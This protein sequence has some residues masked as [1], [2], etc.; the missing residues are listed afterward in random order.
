ML[1]KLLKQ[2]LRKKLLAGMSLVLIATGVYFGYQELNKDD[3]A[4]RYIT[5]AVKKGTLI[6][7]LS[8]S[9]QVSA[10]NQADI[11]PKVSGDVVYVGVKNG[12][13]VKAGTLIAQL[14]AQ[15]AQKAVRDAEINLESAQLSLDKLKLQ[16]QQELRGDTLNKTYED[17][18]KVLADFYEELGTILRDVDNILFGNDLSNNKDNI[19]YYANYFLP[20]NQ[21]SSIPQSAERLFSDIEKVYREALTDF[22]NAQRGSGDEREQAI[23]SGYKLTVKT[24]Q[25]IKFGRDAIRPLYDAF[26]PSVSSSIHAKWDVIENHNNDLSTYAST[27][28]AS[29]QSLL[30]VQN[31]INSQQDLIENQP[32]DLRSQEI[33][34]KQRENALLDAQ[35]KLANYYIRAPFNGVIAQ[36]NAKKGDSV[37]SAS[38]LATLITRQKLA[39]ISLNEVDVAQI[40]IG[41]KATLTFDAVP[42]LTISGQVVEVDAVGTVSQGVVTYTVK[43]G[44]DTQDDRVKTGMSVS[45]AIVT[46]VKPDILLVPNSA[47]KS[48]GDMSYVEILEEGDR[49]AALTAN[50]NGAIL[51]NPPRRQAVKTGL[52]ND[53][54]TEI[55]SG[56]NE[57]D[58]VVTRTIQPNSTQT[59]TQSSQGR[60]KI[61]V[62]MR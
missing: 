43:I 20:Y 54:F 57:G 21:K 8:G 52:S 29:L 42:D 55:I 14:D 17:G 1:T 25:L 11:K 49:D 16:Q 18:M 33:T 45:A 2:I 41:Q 5:A 26:N 51:K 10:S 35:E 40:K 53:E 12:Q 31:S 23:A 37:S 48:E 22:Q 38:I 3:N 58:V 4:T 13:E 46:K 7:S 27:V 44:F 24:A 9:G 36:V 50:M 56:L 28:D 39:E 32:L 34:V 15:D 6:V 60:L 47:V 19:S 62:M 59:Q 61:P 30:T